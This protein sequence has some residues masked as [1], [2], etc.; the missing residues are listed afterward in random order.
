MTRLDLLKTLCDETRKATA[1]IIMPTQLQKGDKK[2][3]FRPAD[4]YQMRLPNFSAAQKKAPYIIHQV[5]TSKDIQPSGNPVSSSTV[6]RSI[7]CIYNDNEEEGALML[8]NLMERLRIHLLEKIVIG[9]R[10]ELNLEVGLETL[11][12]PD[13]TAPFYAGEMSST[14]KIPETKRKVII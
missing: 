9:N 8:L 2:Q 14:W 6:I 7:F 11:I 3:L 12:Y 4:M 1:D 5:I 13:D 10:Y